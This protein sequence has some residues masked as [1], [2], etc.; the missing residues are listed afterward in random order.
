MQ[1]AP[2]KSQPGI[3]P[4][5]AC[6]LAGAALFQFFGNHTRG[7]IDTASLFYW[8]GYQWINP[9]SETQHG[10]VILALAVWLFW[11]NLRIADCG[12]SNADLPNPKSK[13][14]N[15]Q[16]PAAIALTAGLVLHALG[17]IAQQ[18]RLSIL[19]L[20]VFTWGVLALVQR[21]WARAAAFPLG[22]MVF[23]IPVNFLDDVG[24]WLR[25]IVINTSA[26][27]AHLVGIG[28]VQN[29]TQLVSPDGSY[30]YD[31]AAAC[32]G[33][34]SLMALAA[35]SL[36]VGYLR[37]RPWWLRA[38]MLALCAPLA[39][40]GN[41]VRMMAIIVAA[42]IGGQKWGDIAH[43]V[44]G[45]GVFVIVLGGVLLAAD[46]IER[47]RP[48]WLMAAGDKPATDATV[49]RGPAWGIALAIFGLTAC[50]MVFLARLA[51]QAPVGEAGVRLAEDG[52]NPAT[53]PAFLS[54][55][56]LGLRAEVTP[57]E[58]EILPADTGYS[59][60]L[61]VL[62]SD[63]AAKV[64]PTRQVLVSIVLSGRDRTSIHR[65]ELCLVGQ[66][67]TLDGATAGSFAY[68]VRHDAD[69]PVTLLHLR[70][71][72][73][74]PRGRE[75][76]PALVAY[77]FVNADG[78]VATHWRRILTDGWNRLTHGRADRWAYVLVQTGAADGEAAA[79]A[80]M[81]KVL[82]GTLPAFQSARPKKS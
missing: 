52:V 70:R 26:A 14:R 8:W 59:R 61:Y 42:Q 38:A 36:F 51:A 5:F 35:L 43:E 49:A 79:L 75:T 41:I 24:F 60:R 69:F 47:R 78:V 20:L 44:M 65:P 53:L 63:P 30:H 55:E 64:N 23:A 32:S 6:A 48:D 15:P 31:V 13:I 57:I 73:T 34:R 40:L 62:E 80:R 81:Q 66:G 7:Y 39:L 33:V 18:S 77:W 27:L 58:R 2:A 10:F 3:W 29:G 12:S 22:F 82:D 45:V 74:T 1:S 16:W 50:E 19:A 72:V 46:F 68:P 21:S 25:L 9:A 28:V 11:R 76:V 56:W 37:F 54:T 67:W 4:V 17:F 71:V